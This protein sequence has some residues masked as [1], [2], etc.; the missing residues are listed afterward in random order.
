[1]GNGGK[2]SQCRTLKIEESLLPLSSGQRAGKIHPSVELAD[3]K[4]GQAD[5]KVV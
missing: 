4:M 2:V 3:L 1:M 5:K